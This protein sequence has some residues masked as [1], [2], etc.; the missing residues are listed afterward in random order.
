[1][2]YCNTVRCVSTWWCSSI[3]PLE[4]W[5]LRCLRIVQLHMWIDVDI[6]DSSS[7]HAFNSSSHQW[8]F[9]IVY[10][11]LVKGHTKQCFPAFSVVLIDTGNR[12][13][14][15]VSVCVSFFSVTPCCFTKTK[16]IRN[17]LFLFFCMSHASQV[18]EYNNNKKC[19]L[20]SRALQSCV[21]TK[22]VCR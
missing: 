22:H 1:M 21:E 7:D 14:H 15:K 16:S 6:L 13:Y 9:E 18:T 8:W 3:T 5:K 17:I 4:D 10:L 2:F 19:S 11:F 20:W 12:W